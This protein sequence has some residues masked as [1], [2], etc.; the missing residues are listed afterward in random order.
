MIRRFSAVILVFTLFVIAPLVKAQSNQGQGLEISPPLVELKTDPGKTVQAKIRI[1][2]VTNQT[3][4]VR[5]EVNDFT[6]AG[7]DGQPR[8]LLD[9]TEKSPYSLKEW[10]TTIPEVTLKSKEQK[11]AIITL[12]VPNYASPGGHY[13]VVRFTGTPAGVEGT[14][15]SLS[16]SIGALILV[17]VSGDVKEEA[18]IAEIFTAQDNKKRGF[19]EYGPITLFQRIENTGNVHVKPSGTIRVINM[20]GQETASF[21]LNDNGG[22]ILPSSVRKFEQQLNQKMLFG[23]YKL[24]ADVVYGEDNKIISGSTTFWVIPYKLIIMALAGIILIFFVIKRYNKI[25]VKR[26]Q[27]KAKK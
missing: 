4:V 23:R 17:N 11:P 27:S 25:I 14:G 5:S 19:F 8:L 1:R 26:A 22:N 13:G 6:A 9:G 12:Q 24:Q 18:T 20:F 15:V 10:I 2:N 21:S 7:E 3:L 16:A